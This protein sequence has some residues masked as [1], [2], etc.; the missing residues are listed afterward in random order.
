MADNV[1]GSEKRCGF[2]MIIE[3]TIER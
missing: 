2:I 3:K 1:T